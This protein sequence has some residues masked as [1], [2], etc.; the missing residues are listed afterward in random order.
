MDHRVVYPLG[1][2]GAC[3]PRFGIVRLMSLAVGSRSVMGHAGAL[4]A[5]STL[6]DRWRR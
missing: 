3:V 4:L 5:T 2:D 6:L 1:S